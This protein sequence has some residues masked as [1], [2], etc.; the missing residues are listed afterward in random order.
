LLVVANRMIRYSTNQ[1]A[2]KLGL[3]VMTIHRYIRREKIPV[4]RLQSVGGVRV[5]LWSDADIEKVRRILPKIANGRKAR[6]KKK[7][8]KTGKKK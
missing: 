1:A 2:R 6:H 8:K 5:R 4:P 7:A 3:S